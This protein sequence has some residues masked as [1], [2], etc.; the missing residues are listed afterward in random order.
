ML[1]VFGAALLLAPVAAPPFCNAVNAS[2]STAS[3][4]WDLPLT[5]VAGQ[6]SLARRRFVGLVP[7]RRRT[8]LNYPRSP[9]LNLPIGVALTPAVALFLG[10]ITLRMKGHYLPFGDH[11]LGHQPYYLRQ[12]NSSADT[13]GW[14]AFLRC[15]FSASNCAA[16]GTSLFRSGDRAGDLW[17][18][19]TARFA[20]GRAV[21]RQGRPEMAEAFGVDAGRLKIVIRVRGGACASR[22]GCTRTCSGS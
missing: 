22:D 17:A 2:A 19:R 20:P 1:L 10:F 8:S 15:L 11:R 3:W 16:S 4:P 12:L 9:W 7:I 18:T 21:R 5:G 14:P 6:T 13:P